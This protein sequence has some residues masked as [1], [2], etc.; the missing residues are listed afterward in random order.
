ME[1]PRT[2]Q[3]RTGFTIAGALVVFLLFSAT[4]VV[5][6]VMMPMAQQ[7]AEDLVALMVF[8]A[9]TWVEL[10]PCTRN[11]F[12]KELLANHGIKVRKPKAPLPESSDR[13]PYVV[14][15]EDAMEAR[16]KEKVPVLSD[17]LDSNWLWADIPVGER[18]LRLG[19][20][21]S[22]IGPRP[23]LTVFLLIL[24][25]TV[26]TLSTTLLLVRRLNKPLARLSD[27]T[28]R[29]G[30]GEQP[31][32]VPET[33]PEEIALLTRHFNQ[34]TKQIRELLANRT[35]LLA[36]I[37]HD[38]RTPIS[39]TQLALEMMDNQKDAELVDSIRRD[40]A[41]MDQ[42]IG[43]ALEM[44]RGLDAAGKSPEAVDIT[45]LISELA[46]SFRRKQEI[47]WQPGAPCRRYLS[48]LAFR[49]VVSNLLENAVRYGE[50]NGISLRC[51]CH[52][53][54]VTVRVLDR[55]RGIP[56]EQLDRVFQPFHRLETSRS[57]ATGGSGL[58]LAIVQQLCETH[59]WQ[60]QLLPRQG[61]GM[62]ARLELP[63]ATNIS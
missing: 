56:K 54:K 57:R 22:R 29:F 63:L 24:G 60:I 7:S 14:Y 38:L 51:E 58:G 12:E 23:P 52:H 32:P 35:T 3:A 45:E 62:E 30:R 53:D 25:G 13:T 5:H 28:K 10:P 43:R 20:P 6:Y 18:K 49:R 4:V 50:E 1:L 16:L 8:S 27:A 61:G 9:Q 34:M 59:G 41:E 46:D 31:D 44:A 36:G 33:G 47:D 15:F 42:M 2:L 37:S 11:D 48:R 55:G 39:R 17:E 40:L 21:R 26:V 19:F